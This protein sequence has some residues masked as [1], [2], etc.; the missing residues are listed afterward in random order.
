MFLFNP[1]EDTLWKAQIVEY[2]LVEEQVGR[3]V[4]S[5]LIL[6]PKGTNLNRQNYEHLERH[7][8]NTSG[9]SLTAMIRENIL[10]FVC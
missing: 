6:N 7:V 3:K 9:R 4:N 5:R 2:T 10:T 8:K 1:S